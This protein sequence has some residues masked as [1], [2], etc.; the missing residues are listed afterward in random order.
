M[1]YIKV[2]SSHID[3]V[4]YSEKLKVLSIKFKS[5]L[6]IYEYFDVPEQTYKDFLEAESKGK[7]FH[8]NIKNNFDFI[9]TELYP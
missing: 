4:S 3:L 5:G 2:G 6:F 1:K 7:F 9:K 8:K